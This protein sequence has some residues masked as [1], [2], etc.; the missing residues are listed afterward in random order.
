MTWEIFKRTFL[1][2]I[3]PTEKREAKVVEFINLCQGGMSVVEN[4]FKFT[5][6]SKYVRS[7]VSDSR[8]ETNLFVTEVSYDLQEECH[9]SM[10]H[11]KINISHLIVHAQQ[12]E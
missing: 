11:D 12:V 8:D 9:L 7:L 4:S 1:D 6:L 2:R 3:F 10:L 5:K